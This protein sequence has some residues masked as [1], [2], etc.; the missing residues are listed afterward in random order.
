[1]RMLS[2]INMD[3]I[4]PSMVKLSKNTSHR[5]I[6]KEKPSECAL[7]SEIASHYSPLWEKNRNLY[8]CCSSE[9]EL[10]SQKLFKNFIY[11]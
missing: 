11:S 4:K 1:M 2:F 10:K 5:F 6:K 9:L 8:I 3:I 7:F